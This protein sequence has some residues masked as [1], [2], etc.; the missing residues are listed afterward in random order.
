[1]AAGA[2]LLLALSSAGSSSSLDFGRN[3]WRDQA[4][5]FELVQRSVSE[6]RTHRLGKTSTDKNS[7]SDLPVEGGVLIGFHVGSD[8]FLN[9]D[10][11]DAIRP[12]YLTR[13]GEKVGQW[14]GRV[15][16]QSTVVK[17]KQGYVVSG[18]T[19]RTG[20]LVDGFSLTFARLGTDHLILD[21]SYESPWIGSQGGSAT[22]MSGLGGLII[23]VHGSVLD[24]GSLSNLGLIQAR[25]PN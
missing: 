18:M 22:T 17:A 4:E 6:N 13:A 14:H 19:V 20:M 2:V 23:G 9:N 25:L 5:M 3:T 11:V 7:F 16:P 21:D 12:I 24:K 8:K 15:P 10:V 1:M